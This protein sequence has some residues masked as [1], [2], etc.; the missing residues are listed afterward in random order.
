VAVEAV[1]IAELLST[2]QFDFIKMDIE[3]AE[4]LVLPR[5]QGLLDSVQHM[6]IEYYSKVGHKQNLNEILNLLSQE[7]FRVYMEN[8]FER[9]TPFLGLDSYAGFDFQLN[10]YAWK[11]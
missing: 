6:F 5:C 8:P 10:I 9:Q 3:G 11:D 4:D 2:Q 7:G 1:D